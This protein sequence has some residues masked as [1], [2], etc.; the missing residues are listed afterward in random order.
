VDLLKA[1]DAAISQQAFGLSRDGRSERKT[2]LRQAGF[3]DVQHLGKG[4]GA[5]GSRMS[6]LKSS[7]TP[8][9]RPSPFE[10]FGRVRDRAFDDRRQDEAEG[11]KLRVPRAALL[12]KPVQV[13][14]TV[15][16]SPDFSVDDR[17]RPMQPCRRRVSRSEPRPI[18]AIT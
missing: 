11:R 1:R 6:R 4:C 18:I 17:S 14:A 3:P 5:F 7:P 8:K 10:E 9:A 15:T 12:A 13:P 2:L 16:T